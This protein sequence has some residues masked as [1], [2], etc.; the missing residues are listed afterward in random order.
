MMEIEVFRLT[1]EKGKYYVTTTCTRKVGHWPNTKYYTTNPLQYVGEFVKHFQQG[2]ADG[3][4]HWDIFTNNGKDEIVH[5]TYEGTTCFLEV[6]R[7]GLPNEIKEELQ[8]KQEKKSDLLSLEYS[9]K[10]AL[11]TKD[12]FHARQ[13]NIIL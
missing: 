4:Q 11:S 8:T 13:N 7:R 10:N 9:A 3:A 2:W 6:P 12:L 1:P 5:Y